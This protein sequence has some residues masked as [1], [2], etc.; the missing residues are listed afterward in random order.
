M[1][2]EDSWIGFSRSDAPDESLYEFNYAEFAPAAGDGGCF[3]AFGYGQTGLLIFQEVT[4][5]PGHKYSFTGAYKNNSPEPLVN[6]WVELILSRKKPDDVGKGDY[7][8]GTGDYIYAI[9]SWLTAPLNDM[10][11]DGTFQENFPFTLKGA[12]TAANVDLTGSSEIMVPDTV[13]NT[14]W[15]V[16]FKAGCWTTA[17]GDD[18]APF[19]FLVDNISL[20]DLGIG[21]SNTQLSQK[22]RLF[23]ISPNPSYGMLTLNLDKLSTV[24]YKIADIAGRVVLSGKSNGNSTL[25]LN[26]LNKGIYLMSVTTGTKTESQKFILK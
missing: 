15:Y 5:I 10:D 3:K 22:N 12:T 6:T 7:G 17:A 18:S 24:S 14:K 21:N 4:I 19:I 2:K 8:A 23:T 9:N 11:F 20:I 25:N 13:T 26:N 16:S 1:S